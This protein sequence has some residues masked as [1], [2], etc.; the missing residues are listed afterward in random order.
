MEMRWVADLGEWG[1]VGLGGGGDD[2]GG[3]GG[4]GGAGRE[5]R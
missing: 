5:G 1:A 2:E 4:G 3:G